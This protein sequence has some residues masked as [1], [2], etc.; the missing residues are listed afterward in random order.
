MTGLSAWIFRF[1]ILLMLYYLGIFIVY[2]V[3]DIIE[4]YYRTGESGL[5]VYQYIFRPRPVEVKIIEDQIEEKILIEKEQLQAMK[6]K[7]W[8]KGFYIGTAVVMVS[9]AV[10]Q[11]V[12][13]IF[14]G[15]D[16]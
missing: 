1:F 6:E 14:F 10:A 9:W 4:L 12:I 16:D 13:K 3:D 2:H 15:G 7:S 8:S 5:K 11:I